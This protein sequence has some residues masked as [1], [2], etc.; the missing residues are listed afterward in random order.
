M[1]N[2][3]PADMSDSAGAQAILD[4]IRC[5]I[6]SNCDPRFASNPDPPQVGSE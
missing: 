6:A 2:L 1:V 3:T 4:G 5:Q